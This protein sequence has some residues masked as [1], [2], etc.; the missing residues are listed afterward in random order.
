MTSTDSLTAYVAEWAASLPAD[1]I[2]SN[3]REVATRHVLDGYGLA[4]SG[5]AE[6]SHA[7]LRRYLAGS[8]AGSEAHVLG[9]ARLASAEL[10]ALV[11]GLGMHAMDF[12]DT[13]LAT[14]PGSVYGLLTHPTAPVLGA[15][16]AVA[17]LEGASGEELLVAYVIGVEVACRIADA[18]NPRHY[19]DGFHSTGTIGAFGAAAA[20]GRL[21][22]LDAGQMRTAL[23]I[24]AP[25]G[26]GYRE[27]FGTMSK[28]LHA[29][30]A[31]AGGVFAARLAREGFTAA[32]TILEA[33]RGFYHAAAGD[34]EPSRIEGRLGDPFFFESPGI[35]IKPYPS[36]SL[37]HPGQDAVLELIE[38]YDIKPD[39]VTSAIAATNSA[40]TNALIYPM[41]QTA[42]EGKFSF[43]FLLAIAI[44]RR[45]VGV[46]EFT[47][48]V[49]TSPEVQE[50]MRRCRHISDPE[51][52]ARGFHLMETRI[53]IELAD[54]RRV[55][56]TASVATGHPEKPMSRERLEA[57][58]MECATLAIDEADARR[59]ADMI[60]D[61]GALSS[62]RELHEV[63]GGRAAAA[64]AADGAGA[65]ERA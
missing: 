25:L 20:A 27:N 13:Q 24:A 61:L 26:G 47:D 29:G 12:D 46:E 38:E 11:N 16:S 55:T 28:P 40:T 54:G 52:D 36:G 58:F 15:A 49:V 32:Q 1:E 23:G 31:A 65:Q 17:E 62:V 33:P 60:W 19:Q 3:V 30:Q 48:A 10:A 4:L 43:P 34:F 35:S 39:D 42:L 2:P 8:G 5:H 63:L 7:I 21:M 57:K 37:S 41:P 59:A 18:V 50:M 6:E 56:R 53:E 45:K 64:A 44:L 22:G 14:D 51:I 9:S